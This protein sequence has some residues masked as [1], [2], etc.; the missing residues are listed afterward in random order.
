M[1]KISAFIL[2]L[3][4]VS[5]CFAQTPV[6]IFDPFYEDLTVWENIGIINYVPAVRPYP[7]QEIERILKIVMEVGDAGQR[8]VAEE[9]QKRIFGRAVHV[10][11][12]MSIGFKVPDKRRQLDM[13]PL[14][15][16]NYKLHELLSISGQMSFYLTNKVPKE[17]VSPKYYYSK[18]DLAADDVGSKKFYILPMFN[19]GIGVGNST[20]YFT[21][22]IARTSYGPFHDNGIFVNKRAPHQGQFNFVINKEFFSFSQSFLTLTAMDNKDKEKTPRKF[23]SAHS[24]DI[25]PLHWLSFGIMD[26]VIYGQRF[27]PL[28]FIPFSAFFVSQGMYD[29]PDNSFI[30]AK[31]T[32][33]PIPG[34]R[35]DGALYAD[36]IGFNEIVKFKKDAKVRMA[37]EF[38]VSYTM[39]ET[40]WF[41]RIGLDY[42]F[43][44][45]YAYTHYSNSGIDKPNYD[46][47]THDGIPLGANLEPNSDRINLKLIFKPVHGLRIGLTNTFIRH[48]N[49]TESIEDL[50]FKL[51]YMTKPYATDGSISNHA[52]IDKANDGD[53]DF[54][55]RKHTFL[56]STPFLKQKTIE[57]I[58]QLGLDVTCRLPI[59]RSG[60][61]ME[62]TFGYVFEAD[63]NPGINKNIYYISS[64][65]KPW[66]DKDIEDAGV[67][68]A[69]VK[70]EADKQ[71]AQWRNNAKGKEFKHYIKLGVQFAY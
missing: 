49:V 69:N 45:P 8:K 38:G 68:E 2:F 11:G 33:K 34:L 39:P 6:D 54:N 58:N 50:L 64:T 47:Y 19:S 10:G 36:D 37:G 46:D 14:L 52:T 55:H 71:L 51:K 48:G 1:K 41:E 12:K 30:G 62:F 17:E 13:A 22:A 70:A 67:G 9:H 60:G 20:Y 5:L 44:T 61:Y 18:R 3:F 25:R 65:S 4:F 35:I 31:F 53:D 29:F 43:V 16:V 63:I 7:L 66:I 40:H 42:T 57:Y 23:L 15:E 59:K 26:A 27:E 32:I 24:L 21:A 56:Y 28:Y